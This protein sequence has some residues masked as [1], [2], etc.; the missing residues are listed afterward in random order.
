M[1]LPREHMDAILEGLPRDFDLTITLIE[2][3]LPHINIEEAEGYILVQ[4]LQL[5][6]YT[7]L[8]S[9]SNSFTPTVNLTQANSSHSIDNDNSN[10][11][12]D[13]DVVYTN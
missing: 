10:L 2:S 3:H 12:S 8:E 6:K 9:S 5:R 1:L 4:K 11:Y 13:T 7:R